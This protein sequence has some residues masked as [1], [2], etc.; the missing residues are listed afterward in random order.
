MKNLVVNKKNVIFVIMKKILFVLVCISAVTIALANNKILD[1]FNATVN[2]N[3]EIVNLEWSTNSETNV[4]HFEIE[5]STVSG[6][7]TIGTQRAN[8]R[9]SIYKF[10]DSDSF[11]KISL[12]DELQSPNS[13]TYRLKIV[14]TNNSQNF[15]SDEATVYRSVNSIRR[16][17][18]MIKEMFR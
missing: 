11:T 8:G 3:S 18:G 16:T 14:Y 1:S 6:F 9:P 10:T 15:Y 13:V 5:R 17:L 4:S 12:Q 7:K 2:N